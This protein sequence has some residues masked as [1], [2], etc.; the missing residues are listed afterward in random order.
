MPE[1]GFPLSPPLLRGA[2]IQLTEGIGT[3]IPNVIPFQY[4]PEKVSRSFKPWNPFDVDQTNRASPAPQAAPYDPEETYDFTLQLD[5]TN[6]LEDG[7]PVTQVTG[8]A[9]RIASIQKLVTPSKG[10][11]GDLIGTAKALAS[12]PLDKQAERSSI[13]VALLV[14]GPGTVLPVRVTSISIEVTEFNARLYPL[15][16]GVT[17]NLRVLTPESFKCKAT[18]ATELARAAYEFT[19]LQED[20]LAIANFAN[21]L[22]A[23]KSMLPF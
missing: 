1:T 21:A 2:I 23:A 10:L 13:P 11:L 6:D 19:R 9:A 15:M 18:P 14:L 5:A 12:Q 22:S 17:L 8:V 16:A 3:V 4:N 7:N 20:A